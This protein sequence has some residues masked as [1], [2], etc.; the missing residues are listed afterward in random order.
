MATSWQRNPETCNFTMFQFCGVSPVNT[1]P[2]WA[3]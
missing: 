2:L 3:N 1:L